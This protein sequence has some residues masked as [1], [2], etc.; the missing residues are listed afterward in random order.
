[1]T[2]VKTMA[3]KDGKT[4]DNGKGDGGWRGNGI[5]DGDSDGNGDGDIDG[6][7]QMRKKENMKGEKDECKNNNQSNFSPWRHT[8][9]LI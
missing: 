6:D 3:M 9:M 2:M 8:Y 7:E 5:G 4:N 1:M